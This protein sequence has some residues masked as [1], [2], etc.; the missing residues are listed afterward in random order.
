MK[1]SRKKFENS[2]NNI[3]MQK[4]TRSNQNEINEI[5]RQ[6][7]IFSRI[8]WTN[9]LINYSKQTS[10][11]NS[12]NQISNHFVNRQRLQ[13]I[14][15]MNRFLNLRNDSV[16][17]VKKIIKTWIARKKNEYIK[18]KFKKILFNVAESDDDNTMF[19]DENIRIYRVFEKTVAFDSDSKKKSKIV[20]IR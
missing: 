14:V 15:V 3:A 4:K 7:K 2:K 5:F 19:D 20:K 12:K 13:K 10:W 16:S 1:V 18:K 8:E 6:R 9:C 17:I 11:S